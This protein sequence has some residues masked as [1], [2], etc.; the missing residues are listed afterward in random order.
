MTSNCNEFLC[1]ITYEGHV[2][3]LVYEELE[4]IILQGAPNPNHNLF[5]VKVNTEYLVSL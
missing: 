3:Q 4:K 2:A 5:L 1:K